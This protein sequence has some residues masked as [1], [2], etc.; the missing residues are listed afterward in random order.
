[1]KTGLQKTKQLFIGEVVVTATKDKAVTQILWVTKM[2]N[3]S[4]H[5]I[6]WLM[7]EEKQEPPEGR[8]EN[9][10]AYGKEYN[11]SI[12]R[13][14]HGHSF[15]CRQRPKEPWT[16]NV[17]VMETETTLHSQESDKEWKSRHRRQRG[18]RR[19]IQQHHHGGIVNDKG[20][21]HE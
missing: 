4:V 9:I 17:M 7:H 15:Q 5:V 1:M 3:G 6:P 21:V 19:P 2:V 8:F 16:Y 10:V 12:P 18:R 13:Q 14:S 11:S 20:Y